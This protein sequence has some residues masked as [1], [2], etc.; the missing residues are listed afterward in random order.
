[1]RSFPRLVF[2]LTALHAG[3]GYRLVESMPGPLLSADDVAHLGMARTLAGQGAMD[4]VSQPPYGALYPALL[5][6][7]WALGLDEPAMLDLARGINAVL[8]ALLIPVLYR[9]VRVVFAAPQWWA[10]TAA[11]VGATL[12]AL[13]LTGSI[14]WTE[15]LLALLVAAAA[16]AVAEQIRRP[17]G[18][19]G[20]WAVASAVAMPAAHP[21]ML[22]VAT[23]VVVT[24]VAVAWRARSPRLAVGLGAAA[25]VGGVA[26]EVLRRALHDATFATEPTYSAGSLI[27]RRGLA[28]VPD[29][30]V[31][32]A[33]TTASLALGTAGLATLGAVAL[34]RR[35]PDGLV[36][37]GMLAMLTVTAGWFLTGV[38]RADAWLH[39]RYVEVAAPVFVA[40]G[41]VALHRFSWRLSAAV[42][43]ASA[44]VGGIVAAWAG[45]GDTWADPRSPVMMLGVDVM[46]APFGADEFAPLFAAAVAA[47]VGLAL[48][49]AAAVRNP[50]PVA[51]VA[52]V[53]VGIG[54]ASGH[55]NLDDLY[56]ASV[57]SRAADAL[58]HVEL[59]DTTNWVA[60]E[61][62]SLPTNIVLAVSWELG[63]D[64]VTVAS[65]DP[66]VAVDH[67]LLRV[68]QT[69]PAGATEVARIDG[70][71]LWRLRA[72]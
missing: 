49:A 68:D 64:T 19:A 30:V 28:E 43:A 67:V 4:W 5:A 66:D 61:P 45:P 48:V 16:L 18:W 42:V 40:A 13:V 7:G 69:P 51:V 41:V 25:M 17:N 29:M 56:D 46:G 10:L 47:A 57:A 65:G 2:A 1:V 58:A 34:W 32:A 71:T 55:R 44:L 12:P 52:L 11:L 26:V 62:G 37:L 39:G 6:P 50:G 72:P 21:R 8:G 53:A 63:L 15:R 14:A 22:L 35:R 36:P 59:D 38:D 31:H 33:G 9:L 54:I 27:E 60:V 23:F 3:I 20:W 70:A 24:A